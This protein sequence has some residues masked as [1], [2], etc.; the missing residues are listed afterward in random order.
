[1]QNI[2]LKSY[3]CNFFFWKASDICNLSHQLN[4]EVTARG[5]FQTQ[6]VNTGDQNGTQGIIRGP[7]MLIS[8]SLFVFVLFFCLPVKSAPT[9][10]LS[11]PS[12]SIPRS[13]HR[14]CDPYA[15]TL[16]EKPCRFFSTTTMADA[17]VAERLISDIGKQLAARKTCP[18]KDLLVKLLR[19][20]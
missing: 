11:K 18:N 12:L 16:T 14:N 17:E 5:T 7:K 1:M 10:P 6:I 4:G 8:L 13:H 9:L 20:S 19:V 15:E 3:I 2:N